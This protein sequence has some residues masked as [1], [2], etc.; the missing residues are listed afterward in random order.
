LLFAVALAQAADSTRGAQLFDSLACIQCHSVKSKGAR[1]APDLG[2]LVDRSFTPA[3]LAATMWNHAP[4]MWEA[5]RERSIQPGD[6]DQRA[7]EDLFTY[8]YS[9]RFFEKPG[10]AARGKRVFGH[11]KCGECHGLTT[12]LQSGIRPVSQWRSLSDPI[13]LAE[14]MWN[15]WPQM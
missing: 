12:A 15:H 9:A 1:I 11:G 5:M 4:K 3:T 10:D 14:Q 6:L 8:F 13:T 7:A 2:R